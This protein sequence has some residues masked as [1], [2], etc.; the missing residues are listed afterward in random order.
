MTKTKLLK[1]GLPEEFWEGLAGLNNIEPSALE[2]FIVFLNEQVELEELP[3]SKENLDYVI[4]KIGVDKQNLLQGV[5]TAVSILQAEKEGDL[6]EDIL[7]DL[8]ESGS[9]RPEES[10]SLKGKIDLVKNLI[11]DSIQQ[12]S[13]QS[14]AIRN[15]FPI[16]DYMTTSCSLATYIK[17]GFNIAKDDLD[18]YNPQIIHKVPLTVVQM[19]IWKFGSYIR[20][21]FALNEKQLKEMINNFKAAYKELQEFKKVLSLD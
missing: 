20:E 12:H 15:I 13:E 4:G 8:I 1:G 2:E 9:L 11:F 10:S 7:L 19:D 21:S 14:E 5:N 17:P 3:I 6:I 16:I 18:T